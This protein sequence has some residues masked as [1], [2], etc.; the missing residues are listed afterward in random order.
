M[1]ASI[2]AT[3]S[4]AALMLVPADTAVAAED[5]FTIVVIPDTQGYTNTGGIDAIFDQQTQWIVD[6][7]D[8]LDTRFAIH[9][10]DLVESW[11]NVNQWARASRSMA[12]L[13]AAGVPSSVLPGNHDLSITTGESSTY[14][15][16]FPP[17]RYSAAT[18]NSASVR[19]GGYLG[20]NQFGP[21]G[22]DRKN[23]DNYALLDAG[24]LKL[25]IVNLEFESPA[26]SL[27]WAQRVIDAH[28]D[29]RVILATHGF[30]TT[31]GTR[32]NTV[33][34]TDTTPKSANDVWNELVYR[35]C[36]IFMVVNGHWHDGELSEA[37]R[38]DPN[39]CGRPVHQ[40]LSDYQDRA[41]GGNGWLRYYTFHPA[42]DTIDAFT[43]S[44][45]LQQM[46]NDADSRFTLSYDM[47]APAG[48]E[49]VTLLAGGSAW[50]WR[51]EAGAWPTGWNT[52]SFVDTAWARGG[53]PLGRGS[54]SIVTVIDKPLPTTNRPISMLFRHRVDIA[55]AG[56]LS[57]V[58]VITRADDGVVVHV[59]GVEI[60]RSRMPTGTVTSGTYATAAPRTSVAT[61]TPTEFTV[62]A[63]LLHD[64]TNTIAASTHLN[65][66]GTTDASFD[67]VM[68][69][70]RVQDTEPTA[71]APPALTADSTHEDV[72]LSWTPGD[73]TP[74]QSWKITKDGQPLGT[75]A[76]GT[77]TTVDTDVQPATAY[78][79]GVRAVGTTGLESAETRVEVSTDAAPSEPVPVVLLQPGSEWRWQYRTGSWQAGWTTAAFDDGA[80]NRGRALFGFGTAG[81]VTTV[82]V[83]PPTSGRPLSAQFRHSFT[84]PDADALTGV[85]L[86]TRADDGVIV[87][88]NGVEVARRNLP[89]G[90]IGAGSYATA[91]PRTTAAPQVVVTIPASA[92]RDG[93]NTVA[94]SV[95]L[96]YRATP[97]MTFDARIDAMAPP[98]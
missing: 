97:D 27:A 69:A 65:Y 24:G 30:I 68:S 62:P 60:G 9:V 20:Q 55:R 32:S 66:K 25:L 79:Y 72:T 92:L 86:T 57:D 56:E 22:I 23:K 41:N 90:V 43:Y 15:T 58:R 53:A 3:A 71:P 17:S 21:D 63:G 85:T 52:E 48:G 73:A 89:T 81:I 28:P 18:W 84:V 50:S 47:H 12:I 76:G 2:A 70:T 36:S 13:D 74:V 96:N 8:Q 75:V 88:V 40:V 82:D 16:Y 64:G 29:R 1:A 98:G 37:R 49:P 67:L 91:A 54:T 33:I 87:F 31:S 59:N 78:T 35:N 77:T 10:G 6:Q 94:A 26:Y 14:D 45:Y 7:R 46:E 42:T 4:L 83:P 19:Y 38:T 61:A 95:H 93:V 5:D 39:A 34:R 80:W 44:P 11:P 51:Y